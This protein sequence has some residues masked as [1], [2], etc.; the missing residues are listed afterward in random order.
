MNNFFTKDGDNVFAVWGFDSSDLPS[1]LFLLFSFVLFVRRS[2]FF[3]S[4]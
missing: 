3:R 1:S 2:D 4:L